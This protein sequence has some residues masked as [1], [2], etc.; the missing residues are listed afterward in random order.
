M[1]RVW[2]AFALMLATI[3]ASVLG[4]SHTR[5]ITDRMTA[6]VTQA[7]SA[8]ENGDAGKAL[9]L[10]EQAAEDWHDAHDTLGVYMEHTELHQIDQILCGLPELCEHGS[11]DQFLSDCDKV[12]AQFHYM[13]ESEIPNLR[14]IF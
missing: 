5:R 6:T 3:V 8:Q 12:L 4:I 10:S 9:R 1:K 11:E 14:N 13:S 2:F 7:K